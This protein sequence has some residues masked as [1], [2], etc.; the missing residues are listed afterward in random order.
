MLTVVEPAPEALL[1]TR[2]ELVRELGL[3]VPADDE[4]DSLIRAASQAVTTWCG[5]PLA[6]QTMREIVYVSAPVDGLMLSRW[7]IA[8]V[9]DLA[10]G[11]DVQPTSNIE[12]DA[13]AGFL[14]RLGSHGRR[15]A[16]PSGRV[17]VT[18]RAGFIPPGEEGRTLPYDIERATLVLARHYW[19]A[20]GRDPALRSEQVDGIGDVSYGAGFSGRLPAEVEGLLSTYRLPGVA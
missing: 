16:W 13:A 4:L 15:L 12:I 1:T 11:E 9:E 17:S 3:P 14:F 10:F 20:R 19:F 2:A 8:S 5:R 7:P 18:Y 6:A